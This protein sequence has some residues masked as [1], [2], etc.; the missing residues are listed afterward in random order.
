MAKL[1]ALSLCF[2]LLLLRVSSSAFRQ[3]AEENVCQFQRLNALRPDNR[4]DSEGGFI[5]TWNPKSQEFR[6]AGATLSRCTLRRNALRRP[7]YSNAPQQIFIQQG[8]GYFGLIFP[9]CP[10]TFEEPNH[11]GSQRH[12]KV[13]RFKEGDLIA[14]PHGVAFWMYNDQ[15]TDLVTLCFMHTDSFHN[16]LDYFPRKFNLAGKQEQEFLQYQ[17]QHGGPRSQE[18]SPRDH[19]EGEGGNIFSGFTPEFLSHAF[20]VDREI[21][22]NLRGENEREE[23]GPIVTVRGALRILS[24]EREEFDGRGMGNG[25][26]ETICTATVKKNLQGLTTEFSYNPQAGILRNV[27][28]L[29]L[30]IL[31]WLG[32][33]AEY[34]KLYR[35]AMIV[36]HYNLNANSIIYGLNGRAHVQV[37]DCNGN[38]VF[39]EELQE[40]HVLV[41]PQNF[42]VAVRSQS[43]NFEY[44]A[45]KTNSRPSMA[46]LAGENSIVWNLP[47]E[48]V[49]NSYGLPREQARQLKNNNPFK[50]LVPPQDSHMMIKTDVA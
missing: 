44:V 12:Q 22:Q 27:N 26:Q 20:Q 38:R 42:A 7:Y 41:L 50:F 45:F 47:E 16:Q 33:S 40:G 14:V 10:A 30:P 18:F 36:P 46:N 48:V 32:L 4:I 28:D 34:G 2:C 8:S 13:Q 9:G 31:N 25:I 24:P 17:H 29:R 5:E 15:D 3:Q 49:A 23:Q 39:D 19:H 11:R 21:V 1:L 37:V 6:C 43:E 35:N